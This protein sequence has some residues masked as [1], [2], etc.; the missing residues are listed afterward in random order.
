M[1]NSISATGAAEARPAE[2][3]DADAIARIHVA[4]WEATYRGVLR[5]EALDVRT[6]ELRRRV[7]SERL[8]AE[9]PREFVAVVELDGE[10]AGF[11]SGRPALPGEAPG[12]GR[13]GVLEN[14][15]VDP[16]LV[17]TS[18]GLRVGLALHEVTV[19]RLRELGFAE[20]LGFVVDGNDRALRFFEMVGWHADGA[21]REVEGAR[22]SRIRR[23]IE[24]GR[25]PGR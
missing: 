8:A 7:W 22:Q 6:P 16:D 15:Y 10:V 5:D 3:R 2:P 21:S 11:S 9:R 18:A 17:G 13:V 4:S 14:L 12:G 19:E 25:E 20:A 24:P 1:S 23:A